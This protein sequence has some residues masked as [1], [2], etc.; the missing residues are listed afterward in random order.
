ML[1]YV[2]DVGVNYI[3]MS[4]RREE[5]LKEIIEKIDKLYL[6]FQS[7]ENETSAFRISAHNLALDKVKEI[8]K[9]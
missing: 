7:A 4:I 5:I 9:T 3:K 2:L 6:D 8:L 1:N